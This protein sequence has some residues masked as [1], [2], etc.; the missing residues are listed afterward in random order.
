MNGERALGER[1]RR[2]GW[3]AGLGRGLGLARGR[4]GARRGSGRRRRCRRH[5][6]AGGQ[7]QD[8]GVCKVG[9]VVFTVP[10][11]VSDAAEERVVQLQYDAQE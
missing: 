5:V 9:A 10:I 3:G 2:K 11:K 7:K 6:R 1:N 8:E 4:A